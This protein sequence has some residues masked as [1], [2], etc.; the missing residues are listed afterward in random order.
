MAGAREVL[1]A[2]LAVEIVPLY[3]EQ[4]GIALDYVDEP[5]D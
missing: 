2:M 3:R 5:E 1:E 4:V